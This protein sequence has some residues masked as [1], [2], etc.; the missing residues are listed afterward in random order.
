MCERHIVRPTF[1][2]DLT[3]TPVWKMK[4][5]VN[6]VNIHISEAAQIHCFADITWTLP[7]SSEILQ[8][9][10]A[11]NSRRFSSYTPKMCK[12]EFRLRN[13]KFWHPVRRDFIDSRVSHFMM[14]ISRCV[15]CLNNLKLIIYMAAVTRRLGKVSYVVRDYEPCKH[16]TIFSKKTSFPTEVRDTFLNVAFFYVCSRS[17]RLWQ[18]SFTDLNCLCWKWFEKV[19]TAAPQRVFNTS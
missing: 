9:T 2:V 11:Q 12:E 7:S 8:N 17:P 1:P 16:K 5:C 19:L 13:L 6:I 4:P 15:K 14:F 3:L 18:T 10:H